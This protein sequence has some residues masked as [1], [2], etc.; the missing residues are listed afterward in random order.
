MVKKY[1]FGNR[2]MCQLP[3][4]KAKIFW[5]FFKL[6]RGCLHRV[7][8]WC[9]WYGDELYSHWPPASRKFLGIITQ[10]PWDALPLIHARWAVQPA[11]GQW[12]T[13]PHR[14]R[15]LTA[16]LRKKRLAGPPHNRARNKFRTSRRNIES[17]F[18]ERR[19]QWA[20][21]V[22]WLP[23]YMQIRMLALL[24]SRPLT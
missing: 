22:H 21:F 7:C 8:H 13:V 10:L 9:F 24:L 17:S 20:S 15:R 16:P 2:W 4:K 1:S 3:R 12:M 6:E 14:N 11:V 5:L 23:D 18:E 19:W